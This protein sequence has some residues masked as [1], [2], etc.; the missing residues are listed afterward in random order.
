MPSRAPSSTPGPTP[1]ASLTDR[2]MTWA[3]ADT[4]V[5]APPGA[6]GWGRVAWR[7]APVVLL[8]AG[9]AAALAACRAAHRIT[10]RGRAAGRLVTRATCRGV[11]GLL[12]IRLTVQGR[13]GGTAAV[14]NHASWLDILA[15]NATA[16]VLFVAKAEVARWPGIGLLARIAGTVFVRRDARDAAVQRDV[17]IA[18]LN[19]GERLLFFPEGTSTDGRRV[20]AFKPTLF[21]AFFSPNITEALQVQ[22]ITIE[23]TAPD[24]ADPRFY[25]W[26]GGMALAPHLLA[27]LGAPRQGA[28]RVTFHSPLMPAALGNRKALALACETAVRGGFSPTP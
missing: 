14:A 12:R 23:Y 19:R 2:R 11:L 1:R 10:G 9:G 3:S 22:P 25:G 26:W 21:A 18:A 16:P 17:V 5:I 7:G 4:P 28:V 13:P 24:G 6:A 15:L 8:M 20:L 27:V